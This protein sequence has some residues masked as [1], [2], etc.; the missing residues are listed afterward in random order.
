MKK[1][2]DLKHDFLNLDIISVLINQKENINII[3]KT[4]NNNN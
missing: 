3:K 2:K 1:S 4:I